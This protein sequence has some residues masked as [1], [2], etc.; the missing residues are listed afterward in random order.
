MQQE[1]CA[2]APPTRGSITIQLGAVS[3]SDLVLLAIAVLLWRLLVSAKESVALLKSAH[4]DL[5]RL[6]EAAPRPSSSRGASRR[7]SPLEGT[8]S[9]TRLIGVS[10]VAFADCLLGDDDV[11]A[12]KFMACC[13]A[14]AGI[15]EK[16]GSFTLI[17]VREVHSNMAKVDTSYQLAPE[18]F[19]S[20]RALLRE[21]VDSQMHAAGGVI[22]D[23]SAAMGLLWARRGLSFWQALFRPH[24]RSGGVSSDGSEGSDA[25]FPLASAGAPPPA[26]PR[27][28]GT[29]SPPGKS[30]SLFGAL[31][32]RGMVSK[33]GYEAAMQA[34]DETMGPY[35]GWIGRNA[36]TLGARA[37]PD[38]SAFVPA[39]APT[40]DE[41]AE[42]VTQ[43]TAAVTPML[44][45]MAVMHHELDL[46]DQ[47]KSI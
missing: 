2:A 25:D 32:N 10:A 42:D 6:K 34:Y 29:P 5:Q 16:L 38:W 35:N 19:R 20:M 21:E 40:L 39:L 8:P 45:R 26:T 17:S 14:F 41:L 4:K 15:L 44:E 28:R 30:T 31:E 9:P 33:R 27:G 24:L 12:C 22:A 43:W 23:P 36:F 1:D 46:E 7:P 11:D 18:R 47:R 13:R 37:T 3:V